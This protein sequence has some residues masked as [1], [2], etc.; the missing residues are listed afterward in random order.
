[1][2]V[3]FYHGTDGSGDVAGMTGVA[4]VLGPIPGTGGHRSV[5]AA[6]NPLNVLVPGSGKCRP[7]MEVPGLG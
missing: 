3:C 6:G 7:L 5:E 1:M 4:H 2:E